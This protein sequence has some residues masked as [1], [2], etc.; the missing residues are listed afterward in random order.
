MSVNVMAINRFIVFSVDRLYKSA[1]II[2][3]IL[4][5]RNA[6]CVDNICDVVVA[7]LELCFLA[8]GIYRN[9]I[10]E[11]VISVFYILTCKAGDI[12]DPAILV[13]GKLY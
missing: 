13:T 1:V 8:V 3:N 7:V 12:D 6:S 10:A 5:D 2:I 4:C 9:E 11:R